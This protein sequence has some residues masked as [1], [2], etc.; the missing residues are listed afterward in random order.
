MDSDLKALPSWF[1]M[2]EGDR[3]Q[4]ARH[5]YELHQHGTGQHHGE[6]PVPDVR[7]RDDP[8]LAA[9]DAGSASRHAMHVTDGGWEELCW[10]ETEEEAARLCM[11]AQA[12]DGLSPGA[13]P[14][15]LG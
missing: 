7:Y 5:V 3:A 13:P 6:P 12:A 4:A 10:R 1:Q 2:S 9:L 8:A 15:A 11:L 14:S